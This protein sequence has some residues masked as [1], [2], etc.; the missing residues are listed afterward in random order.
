MDIKIFK[1]LN[2]IGRAAADIMVSHISSHGKTVLGLATG[3]SPLSTYKNLI[4][5]YENGKVSFKSVISFNLDEYCSIPAS[6]K[7]SY[8]TFMHRELFDHIDIPEENIHIPDGNPEDPSAFCAQ[9]DEMIKNAG[10]ID[11]QL[12]GIGNNGHIGFNEP[13]DTFKKGTFIVNLSESTVQANM[14]YFNSP[15]EMPRRAVT[16]GIGSIMQA[17]EIILLA[18]GKAKAQAVRDMLKGDITPLC[19][20]SI[21][22]EHPNAHIFL[23]RNAASLI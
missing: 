16:M 22:R 23:D 17:K 14:I 21:L 20:A 11:I 8:N 10:G 7:N 15:E 18:G 5:D 2:E 4:K 9:Y 6:D 12:L 3:A 1:D 13:S 19:P